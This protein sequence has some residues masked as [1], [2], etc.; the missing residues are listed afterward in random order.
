MTQRKQDRLEEIA[1]RK[2]DRLEEIAQR[3]QDRL[4][5]I[6][7]RKQNRLDEIVQRK[8][9]RLEA[10]N[11]RS[12]DRLAAIY[13]R[14]QER[15]RYKPAT[16]LEREYDESPTTS[17]DVLDGIDTSA[18]SYSAKK[19]EPSLPT[20]LNICYHLSLAREFTA[21]LMWPSTIFDTNFDRCYCSSCYNYK[22]KNVVH[23]GGWPYVIPRGWVRLGLK[24]DSVTA[25]LN[26]IWNCWRVT[27]HGT[28][29]EAAISIIKSRQF[30][31]PGDQLLDG[32]FLAIRPG[33]IPRKRH[34]YSSPT[35][36]Y[37]SL[38]VY[39]PVYDFAT[40]TNERYRVKM[41]LECR[42]NPKLMHIQGETVGSGSTRICPYIT[43]D[44]IE[45]FTEARAS[46]VA[47]GLLLHF[48]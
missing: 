18:L 5:E 8:Q 1:Q 35:I 40:D 42:Q 34:V 6:A 36:A 2:Q 20:R 9:D 24:V 26:D 19:N 25:E 29:K 22:W 12:E 11:Q 14:R 13:Q 32:S 7:Q 4:E 10:I 30:S 23:A 44:E 33:H 31:I 39:C 16:G 48:E 21:S 27:Y 47:Y 46:L 3:K 41:V 38:P 15:L 43:N 17:W 37:S 45:Y 28:S